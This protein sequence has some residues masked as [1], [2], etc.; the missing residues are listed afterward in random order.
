MSF[1]VP[2]ILLK[3]VVILPNQEIKVELYNLISGKTINDATTNYKGEIL[4]V[5]PID[6]LEEEPSVEDLPNVGVI[7][8]IKN[9]IDNNGCIQ[10]RLRGIKR[11][12][13]NKYFQKENNEIL[14]SNVMYI[15]LPSLVKEEENAINKKMVETLKEYINVSKGVSNDILS[16]ISACNDLNRITDAV[17]SFL[18]INTT[19]KLEYMQEINP[20]KRAKSLIKDMNEEIK[21]VELDNELENSIDETL[22]QE[23][24]EFYLK[25]KLKVIKEQLGEKSWKEDEIKNY[26]S[27]LDKLK[28]DENIKKHF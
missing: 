5:T 20:I 19:K 4:V 17:A 25:E 26:R 10:V 3:N 24:R 21:I 27:I 11:V 1:N 22:Q 6:A 18:P 8:K 9:K 23:Q 16:F 13:V 14:Y 28:I 7:A 2:V 15:D 12:A